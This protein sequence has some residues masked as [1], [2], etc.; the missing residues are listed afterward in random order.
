MSYA[1]V[2]AAALIDTFDGIVS[3]IPW[4]SRVVSAPL[5]TYVGQIEFYTCNQSF[6][7]KQKYS[8]S[9]PS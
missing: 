4:Q 2:E 6:P 1:T 7:Q 9:A 8:N 3:H 5:L